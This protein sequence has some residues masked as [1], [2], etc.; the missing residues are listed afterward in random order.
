MLSSVPQRKTQWKS[1]KTVQV[2]RSYPIFPSLNVWEEVRGLLPVDGEP[3]PGVGLGV[4]EGLLCQMV[5][6]PE[7]NLF[8]DSVVFESNFV[9]VKKGRNWIDI[10]KA[11][12][13]M[14]VGVTSSVPCLPLPNI[15]L[16]A[17]VKWHQ[18]QSQTWNRP[19]KAPNIILK[20]ILPLKFVELQVC[21]RLQRILRLRTVTEKIYYLRLHPDHPET[22]FHFWIRLVRILQKGLS[23]TTKDPRILVTHCLVPKNSCSPSGDSNLVQKKPQASQPS[24]S[25]MQLMAKGESEALSQI[26]ADLHQPRQLSSRSSKKTQTKRDS[27]GNGGHGAPIS[28]R[29]FCSTGVGISSP[30]SSPPQ[31]SWIS[32]FLPYLSVSSSRLF[33]HQ[34]QVGSKSYQ[35]LPLKCFSIFFSSTPAGSP[36]VHLVSSCLACHHFPLVRSF[37]HSETRSGHLVSAKHCR[38]LP[39]TMKKETRYPPGKRLQFGGV[40]WVNPEVTKTLFLGNI[41]NSPLGSLTPPRKLLRKAGV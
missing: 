7:F 40:R 35:F 8:P 39:I 23:I 10:Y 29:T 5:H 22:V 27:P 3:N 18:G 32:V 15:L 38:R 25:L 28:W 36:L 2:T 4:E 24:E 9:Q 1:K 37:P 11:S 6:S 14:A 21:D 34:S 20:R 33:G 16:M 12:N 41:Q 31:L 19:S 30:S 26:F 17:S 13:T